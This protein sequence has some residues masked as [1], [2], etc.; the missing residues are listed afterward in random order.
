MQDQIDRKP[1]IVLTAA[2]TRRLVPCCISFAWSGVKLR[3]GAA[4]VAKVESEY[5]HRLPAGTPYFFHVTSVIENEAQQAVKPE[6]IALGVFGAIAG[7][8]GRPGRSSSLTRAA[9]RYGMSVP[10]VLGI[11]NALEGGR[12]RNSAPVRS[13]IL[14]STLAI[15]LVVGALTFGNSLDVLT[16]TPRLYGWNWNA[17]LESDDG[18][19]SVPLTQAARQ[20]DGDSSV[21]SWSG[22]Y[23]DSLLFDGQ[24]VPVVGTNLRARVAP[25]LLAGHEIDGPNQVVVGAE[26]LAELHNHLG[27]TVRVTGGSRAG[28]AR[29]C[30]GLSGWLSC[31]QWAL[32]TVS[33]SPLDWEP[34]SITT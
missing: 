14:A 34:L 13:S 25:A 4:D 8:A 26:T 18:Y 21:T 17:M 7:L 6:S 22:I 28:H 30:S 32:D 31:P 3:H 24:A 5:L 19:G 15:M 1:A 23:F 20:L 2:L 9:M 33:I 29:R 16:S 11:R 27:G 12:A 10:A